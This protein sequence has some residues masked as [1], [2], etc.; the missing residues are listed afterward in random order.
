MRT[1]TRLTLVA[2]AAIAFVACGEAAD[3]DTSTDATEAPADDSTTAPTTTAP[4]VPA[5]PSASGEPDEVDD[6]TI[7]GTRV[8]AAGWMVADLSLANNSSKPSTYIVQVQFLDG[9]GAELESTYTITP[10][11]QPDATA[12]AEASGVQEPPGD[13]VFTARLVSVDRTASE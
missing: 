12:T 5:E 7:T 11:V 9:A 1:T 2:L 3:D 8:G 4:P 13:G 6:V 10:D